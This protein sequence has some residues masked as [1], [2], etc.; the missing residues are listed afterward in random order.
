M[1][2]EFQRD[3]VN[4]SIEREIFVQY[5]SD[6]IVN[7][8]LSQLLSQFLSLPL[9]LLSRCF[10]LVSVG[11]D[12]KHISHSITFDSEIPRKAKKKKEQRV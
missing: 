11:Y 10:V 9:S 7:P 6:V 4:R 2:P 1:A 3:L 8:F 12:L 5:R